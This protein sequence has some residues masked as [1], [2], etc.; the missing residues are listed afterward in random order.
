MTATLQ[1]F[2]KTIVQMIDRGYS[3]ERT[4]FI[5]SMLHET[6]IPEGHDEII[7]ALDHYFD[8]PG[9][10]KYAR[11]IREVK[12]SL[13]AQKEA[14]SKKTKDVDKK[15]SALM[16]VIENIL[17]RHHQGLIRLDEPTFELFEF[18]KRIF[19]AETD[20]DI[21]QVTAEISRFKK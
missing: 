1:P 10:V 20:E 14:A 15:T 3:V 18:A 12:E 19:Y 6:A 11:D 8:F 9:A 7:A 4:L 5:M 17:G 2:H 16:I 13:L 21:R